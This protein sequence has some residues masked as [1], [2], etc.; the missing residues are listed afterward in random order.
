[1]SAHANTMAELQAAVKAGAEEI[2][3]AD[4]GLARRVRLFDTLRTVANI[5]VYVIL[6]AAVFMWAD[7]LHL[8]DI[9]GPG[10]QWGRRIA[11]GVGV[12]LLFL[13]YLLPAVRQYKPD[14]GRDGL[15]LVPRRRN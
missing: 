7:P 12:A 6:A 5:V 4:E 10:L 2:V 14:K 1:M 8:F 3:V 9:A 15:V 11:L 13:D